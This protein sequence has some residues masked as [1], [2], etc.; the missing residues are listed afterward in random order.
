MTNIN[1]MAFVDL[2]GDFLHVFDLI[3]GEKPLAQF[4]GE[5]LKA[6]QAEVLGLSNMI[7]GDY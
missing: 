2:A 7:E 5:F 1:E 4:K 3:R 6:S